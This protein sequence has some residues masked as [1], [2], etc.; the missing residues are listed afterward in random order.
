MPQKHVPNNQRLKIRG[1]LLKRNRLNQ[2]IR[3]HYERVRQ[4]DQQI[5][6]ARLGFRKRT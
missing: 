1:L 4:I 5:A 3:T 2:Q 6:E